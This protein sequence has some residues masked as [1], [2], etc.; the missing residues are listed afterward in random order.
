VKHL[1]GAALG[2]QVAQFSKYAAHKIKNIYS[3]LLRMWDRGEIMT[4]TERL[5]ILNWACN[6]FFTMNYLSNRRLDYKLSVLDRT[7]P[8]GVWRIKK[9]LIAAERL[10]GFIQEPIFTDILTVIMPSGFIPGHEDPNIGEYVHTRF[11]VFLQEPVGGSKTY[12]GGGLVDAK[13]RHYT[14]C[15][16]GLDQHWSDP[17]EGSVP[18]MTLSFGFLVPR[19]TVLKMY[20][21]PLEVE[22]ESKPSALEESLYFTYRMYSLFGI[23]SLY[24]KYPAKQLWEVINSW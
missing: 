4:E 2:S 9:R 12:Y 6:I 21:A 20:K 3:E 18:R 19:A 17:I 22:E 10:G 13:E 16:S 14:M 7:V 24:M 1:F 5:E 23:Y 11:N 15:R 8:V